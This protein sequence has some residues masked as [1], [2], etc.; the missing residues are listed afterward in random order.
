MDFLKLLGAASD[1]LGPPRPASGWRFIS[2][3]TASGRLGSPRAGSVPGMA[4]KYH[5]GLKELGGIM[6]VSFLIHFELFSII[7]AC[8]GQFWLEFDVFW[9]VLA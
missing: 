8:F 6:L 7:S 1:G 4:R 3:R 5:V 9:S 2:P